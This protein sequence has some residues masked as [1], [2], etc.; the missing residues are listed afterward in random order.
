[1]GSRVAGTESACLMLDHIN[2]IDISKKIRKAI[3]AVI[4][5]GKVRTYD[6]MKMAGRAN[7][8]EKGAASTREMADAIIAKL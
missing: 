4:Q 3:A 5:E 8:I 2:E 6:M 7:V 1:M